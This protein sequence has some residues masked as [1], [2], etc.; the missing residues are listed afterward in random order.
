VG[1]RLTELSRSHWHRACDAP[2]PLLHYSRAFLHHAGMVTK[3]LIPRKSCFQKTYRWV[4]DKSPADS[5]PLTENRIVV[6]RI[7]SGNAFVPK[8]IATT[9]LGRRD[10]RRGSGGFNIRL[11][12]TVRVTT[13]SSR[14]KRRS[15]YVP[16][17]P[18]PTA[19]RFL[20]VFDFAGP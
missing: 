2:E 11:G 10:A 13:T 6:G 4:P 12:P 3:S 17:V 16:S 19:V 14:T 5:S 20:K 1:G 9:L 18:Q 8:D 7:E 15:V